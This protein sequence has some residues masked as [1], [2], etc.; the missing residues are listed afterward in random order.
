[1]ERVNPKKEM[2]VGG[3]VKSRS[4]GYGTPKQCISLISS[5]ILIQFYPYQEQKVR[6]PPLHLR[7]ARHFASPSKVAWSQE[8]CWIGIDFLEVGG[9]KK[10]PNFKHCFMLFAGLALTIPDSVH[11]LETSDLCG[12]KRFN[13]D[14]NAGIQQPGM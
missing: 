13:N 14:E 2:V 1:M 3:G 8:G 6:C 5:F 4:W 9:G 10:T 11:L 7:I 12:K